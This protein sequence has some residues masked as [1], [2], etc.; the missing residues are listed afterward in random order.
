MNWISSSILAGIVAGLIQCVLHWYPWMMIWPRGLTRVGAYVLGLLGILVPY[1]VL[2]FT[3]SRWAM[4][5]YV[6]L[7]SLAALWLIVWASGFA[8]WGAYRIDHITNQVRLA[9]E[10]AELL[11]KR[12]GLHGEQREID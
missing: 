4:D 6:L 1:S 3:W 9:A 8:V 11:S 5:R 12:E 2:I 7:R 10:R